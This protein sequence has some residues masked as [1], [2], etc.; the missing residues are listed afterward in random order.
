M[1]IAALVHHKFCL[2]KAP[3]EPPFQTHFCG[4]CIFFPLTFDLVM[5]VN[6]VIQRTAF[7]QV[8]VVCS[9]NVFWLFK[10]IVV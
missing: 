9:S 5:L 6:R 3:P 1:A 10:Y 4:R 7:L 2:D 8:I